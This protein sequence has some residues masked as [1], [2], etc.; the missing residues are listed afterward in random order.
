MSDAPQTHEFAS[1]GH[2]TMTS[3]HSRK[4]KYKTCR[5]Y[6]TPGDAHS[7]TFNCFHAQ[8]FLSKDRT[9]LWLID[10]LNKARELLEF[11]IWAYVIMPE[12]CHILIFPRLPTY[13]ISRIL[14]AIKLPVTRRAK[15]YLEH[16]APDALRMMRDEQPNGEVAYRFWQRGGGHDRNLYEPEAIHAEIEYHHSNPV[17][18]GL[19]ARAEDWLWSSAAWYAGVRDVPLVPDVESI[20]PLHITLRFPCRPAA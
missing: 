4:Q 9:R 10:S 19:V 3:S 16:T 13:S 7:L 2:P 12:H 8:A 18:R 11:D 6:N 20:P 15:S 14:E 5:R 1:G 17:R